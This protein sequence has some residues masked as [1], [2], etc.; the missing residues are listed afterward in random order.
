M[1]NIYFQF[2]YTLK[3]RRIRKS[4]RDVEKCKTPAGPLVKRELNAILK[5]LKRVETER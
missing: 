5:G 1:V 2:I 3:L 4:K